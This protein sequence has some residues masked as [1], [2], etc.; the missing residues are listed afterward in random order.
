MN[1][2]PFKFPFTGFN[3]AMTH[4]RGSFAK[5]RHLLWILAA[6][7]MICPRLASADAPAPSPT[8]FTGI[9]HTGIVSIGGE[10]TGT[11]LKTESGT[12]ELD[13]GKNQA[14]ED[15]ADK[16]NG[17]KVVVIGVATT[18]SGVEVKER[19]IIAVQTIKTAD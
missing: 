14:L 8:S 7:V 13:L 15:Q 10:T 18:K 3:V 4:P 6:V 1:Y 19:R 9:L 12:Y 17:K 2:P 11:I 16:L 5:Y